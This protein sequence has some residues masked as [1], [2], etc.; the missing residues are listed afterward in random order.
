MILDSL[1]VITLGS[2]HFHE[3]NPV[4]TTPI[5]FIWNKRQV[6]MNEIIVEEVSTIIGSGGNIVDRHMHEQQIAIFQV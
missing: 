6:C 5:I 3:A 2:K 4:K 1:H